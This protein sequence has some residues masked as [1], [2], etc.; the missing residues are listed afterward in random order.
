MKFHAG[1]GRRNFGEGWHHADGGNYPH[2][3]DHD[4]YLK[5][6]IDNTGDIIYSSHL[7]EYFDREEVVDLLK[8]WNRVLKPGGDL[9]LAV[10]DFEAIT[11]MYVNKG[12]EIESFLG[13]LYG[14]IEINGSRAYHRTAYDFKSLCRLLAQCGFKGMLR[15]DD[16]LQYAEV[17]DQDDHSRA[18]LPH[19]SAEGTS[20]SLNI[21][22]TK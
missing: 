4:V 7:I 12:Y 17:Y 6:A 20:I 18:V 10:P 3:K 9:L 2:V 1:C 19:M 8:G 22:C 11:K 13:P 16:I 21:I 5:G 15:V 14:R